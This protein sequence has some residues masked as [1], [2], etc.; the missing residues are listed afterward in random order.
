MTTV[1]SPALF[2]IALSPEQSVLGIRPDANFDPAE[3]AA[4]LQLPMPKRLFMLSGGA[5]EMAPTAYQQLKSLF[6]RVGEVL[7]EAQTTVIDGG[8]QFGAVAL[9]G[10]ALA[11]AGQSAPYIGVLPAYA[12]VGQ[13]GLRGEDVLEHHH[14]HFV[15]VES[16]EWGEEVQIMYGLADYFSRRAAS[17]AMLVN[18]GGISLQEVEWNVKQGRE[19][20]VIAG[21]GRLAD[22]IATAVRH[23]QAA[24][25]DRIA[26]VVQAGKLTLFDLSESL[27]NLAKLL[28]QRLKSA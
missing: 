19:I 8:T 10:D 7:V 20:I 17:V 23:P 28:R 16:D 3:L 11:Q 22:E 18:G 15:L 26:A 14:S 6:Q 2:S 5:G 24:A 9:L 12:E 27:E 25:R 21:S 4:A 1:T 13:N